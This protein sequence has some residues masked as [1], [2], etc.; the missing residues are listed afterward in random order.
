MGYGRAVGYGAAAA[1]M[2]QALR[3]RVSSET[4]GPP[5]FGKKN[6]SHLIS[7]IIRDVILS[8]T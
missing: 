8:S 5:V 3:I 2:V 6:V 7:P 4:V 1:W